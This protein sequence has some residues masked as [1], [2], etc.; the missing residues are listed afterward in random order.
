MPIISACTQVAIT[1]SVVGST[2]PWAMVQHVTD[3]GG[4]VPDPE[5]QARLW[6]E[7]FNAEVMPV[8]SAAVTATA[9]S[10]VDLRSLSGASG[11]VSGST[12]PETGGGSGNAL[13]PNT[14]I[15][16]KLQTAGGRSTR[17]GRMYLPGVDEDQVTANGEMTVGYVAD[18]QN[19]IDDFWDALTAADIIPVVNS[20][21]PG[22]TY[23][24]NTITS[25]TVAALLATQR[26]RL[27][28]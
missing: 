4:A 28:K 2:R 26:R 16:V 17:S 6:V 15:L 19:A 25:M 20:K 27:R 10:F 7:A 24:P 3:A 11:P 12:L 22:G 9:A 5:D 23:A 21:V 1:G 14:A 18:V 13:A 8:I